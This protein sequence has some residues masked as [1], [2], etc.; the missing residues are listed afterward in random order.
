MEK[1]RAQVA[2]MPGHKVFTYGPAEYAKL[3][4]KLAPVIEDWKNRTK[5]GAEMLIAVEKARGSR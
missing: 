1:N 2:A 3:K 5:G 4:A